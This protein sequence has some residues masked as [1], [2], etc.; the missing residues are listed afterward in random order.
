VTFRFSAALLIAIAAAFEAVEATI[1]Q[2]PAVA[3]RSIVVVSDMHM[4]I[5]RTASGGWHPFED[6]RWSSEFAA[7]LQA[8]DQEGHSAVDLVL[9]GDTF[10][11]L[12]STVDGCNPP[13]TDAGCREAEALARVER[14]LSAHGPEV[15]ALAQFARAG[16]N[17]VVFVPGDH[18]AALTRPSIARRLV[19][20]L[21]APSGRVEVATS[22]SWVSS[23]GKVYAEHGH[24]IGSNPH[25]FENWPAATVTH[26]GGEYLA[27]PWGERAVQALY[28]RLEERYPIV[29]NFALAGAGLKYG[30]AADNLPDAGEAA[31][32]L[33]RYFLSLMSWQQ[34]RMELDG[35]ETEPPTWE[36]AQARAQGAALLVSSLPDD[37]RF[38][39]LAAK[40]LADGR[41]G[42]SIEEWS[43]EEL[44]ALCDYRAA[45]RRA[46]RRG[47]PFLQQFSSRGPVVAECPRTA[48]T[49]GSQFDYFWRSRDQVFGRYLDAVARRQPKGGRPTVFVHGHTHL[50]DRGQESAITL[51]AGHLT[52]PRQ[53]FTPVRGA[54]API[55]ING[56]AW[57]RTITP[58]QFERLEMERGLSGAALLRTLQPE[59]LAPCYSFVHVPPYSD[60]PTPSVRYWRQSASGDWASAA[61]CGR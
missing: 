35:G 22:G 16:S 55:V 42:R 5:G 27:R 40:A 33:L 60:E 39:P 9:N 10:E 24:Q 41:L 20:A 12:Q 51:A 61:A 47:E 32:Q 26:A 31:P 23:D 2:T 3:S 28:N 37:D 59:D 4:G 38:K 18:D 48:D 50:P 21:R 17:R 57:Q 1:L 49:R 36:L 58:V 43:E 11:L 8:V 19:G 34:F 13:E 25:H 6:F 45:S 15:D 7:F 54:L 53:G 29:D 30:L 56:G 46:R 44:V 52:I 14:V